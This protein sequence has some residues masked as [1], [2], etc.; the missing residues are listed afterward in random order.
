MGPTDPFLGGT[1]VL[2]DGMNA[3]GVLWDGIPSLGV[4]ST[5]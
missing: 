3:A 1:P 5:V 2:G 4:D